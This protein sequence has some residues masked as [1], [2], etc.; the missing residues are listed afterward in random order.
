MR[1]QETMAST[2]QGQAVE[3][4]GPPALGS[5]TASARQCPALQPSGPRG[6]VPVTQ[7]DPRSTKL[8]RNKVTK[9]T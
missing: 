3:E 2:H 5:Q 9:S 4:L 8:R 1:T 6:F 7:A